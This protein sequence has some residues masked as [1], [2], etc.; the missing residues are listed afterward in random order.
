[1]EATTLWPWIAL[2]LL[3]ALHG[4]NPGMG[5]LFAVALGLQEGS[6]RAV[7]RALPPLMLG[8]TLAVGAAVALATALGS[9]IGHGELRW[10]IA[11]ALLGMGVFQLT[12]YR[13][14]RFGGMRVGA[15]DLVIWSFLM[16]SA[17]GAGLMA[18]PLVPGAPATESA[19]VEIETAPARAGHNGGG[20]SHAHVTHYGSDVN[21]TGILAT[22]VHT[23]GYVLVAGLIAALVYYRLGLR[24][25]QR[26]WLNLDVLW[27]G[28]LVATAVFILIT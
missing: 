6:G 8:H 25:L 3:G 19:A 12:R 5:W 2:L 26:T 18:L 23:F 15:R 4:L 24:L 11:L 13:H 28:A 9:V 16:A 27:A 14:P 10:G 22:V 21:L 20:H 1:M 7:W 17:H